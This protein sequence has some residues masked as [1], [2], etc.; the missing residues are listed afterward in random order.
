[1]TA[2]WSKKKDLQEI[3][4]GIDER[5]FPSRKSSPCNGY[6]SSVEIYT[7]DTSDDNS[8]IVQVYGR[9]DEVDN[10]DGAGEIE[11]QRSTNNPHHRG[12]SRSFRE[13]NTASS[14]FLFDGRDDIYAAA[15]LRIS[16]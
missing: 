8:T 3:R 10:D 14:S 2:D 6:D 9:E 15:G 1:M 16:L 7:Y 4:A 5:I 12:D 13:K 11:Q